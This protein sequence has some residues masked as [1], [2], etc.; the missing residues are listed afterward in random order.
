MFPALT[1][2]SSGAA[3]AAAAAGGVIWNSPA[4]LGALTVFQHKR[5]ASSL[6]LISQTDGSVCVTK[7]E[8]VAPSAAVLNVTP[9]PPSLSL[10]GKV[11]STFPFNHS[12]IARDCR[13]RCEG[14]VIYMSAGSSLF[15]WERVSL[16]KKEKKKKCVFS[17]P[18][19]WILGERLIPLLYFQE[20]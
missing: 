3:A 2:F 7:L 17:N 14:V 16:A 20:I 15:S 12:L 9:P 6:R 5:A 8:P 11:F 19:S 18:L 10:L 4:A 1:C 13:R